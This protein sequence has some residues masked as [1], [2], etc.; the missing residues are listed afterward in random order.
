MGFPGERLHGHN[1]AVPTT[2]PRAPVQGDQALRSSIS[3]GSFLFCFEAMAVHVKNQRRSRGQR[4][5]VFH[6]FLSVQGHMS[7]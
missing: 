6:A 1:L 2:F 7:S 3:F 4:E 5:A